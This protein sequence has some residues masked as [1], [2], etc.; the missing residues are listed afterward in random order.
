VNSYAE[1]DA[2]IGR[3]SRVALDHRVLNGDGAAHRLDDATKLDQR[4][5]ARSLE[6]TPVLVGDGWVDQFGAQRSQPRERTVFIRARHPTED[7]SNF[8][9]LGHACRPFK[10]RVRSFGGH[11]SKPHATN[12]GLMR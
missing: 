7:C 12:P 8:P 10:G 5:V 1:L 9:G 6:H 2:L 11:P 3:K 4:A